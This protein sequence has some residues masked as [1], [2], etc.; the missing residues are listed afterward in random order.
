MSIV[1]VNNDGSLHVRSR[2][3]IPAREVEIRVTTSG[4]PGGQHANRSLTK[5][6]ACFDVA[7]STVLTETDRTM[8]MERLGRQACSSSSRFRSQSANKAAALESL[9]HKVASALVR[10]APR[11][12]TRPTIGSQIRRVEQKRARSKVKQG[13]RGVGD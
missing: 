5:V 7:A 6:V 11:R 10:P 2:L 3:T 13:R 8:V 1:R 4:G 12:P 9:A